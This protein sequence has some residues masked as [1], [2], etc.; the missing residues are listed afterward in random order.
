[1]RTRPAEF[2]FPRREPRAVF[3]QA[4]A[5]RD[6]QLHRD[7]FGAVHRS[8]WLDDTHPAQ[9]AT[10]EHDVAK[11]LNC[12]RGRLHSFTAASGPSALR[13]ARARADMAPRT[14]G[15]Q[16]RECLARR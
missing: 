1:M 9:A 11:R 16:W 15:L 7:W 4:E 12:L 6:S 3:T 2:S 5:C 14:V 13:C 10:A 8:V